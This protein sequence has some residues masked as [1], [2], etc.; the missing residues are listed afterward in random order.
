MT[1]R[2]RCN[3]AVLF[4]VGNAAVIFAPRDFRRVGVQVLTGDVMVLAELSAT[5]P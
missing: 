3:R 5:Q 1:K 4:A 2:Q